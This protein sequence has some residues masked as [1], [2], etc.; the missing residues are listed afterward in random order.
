MSKA[1]HLL[2]KVVLSIKERH[3]TDRRTR[4]FSI[5]FKFFSV[6]HLHHDDDRGAK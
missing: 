1:E 5:L 6:L 2:G 4:S 3:R